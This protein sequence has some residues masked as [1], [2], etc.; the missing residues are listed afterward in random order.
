MNNVYIH[1]LVAADVLDWAAR[2]C[3]QRCPDPSLL[4][5]TSRLSSQWPGVGGGRQVPWVEGVRSLPHMG[6]AGYSSTTH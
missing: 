5:A 1:C 2:G 3:P 6:Q 4:K